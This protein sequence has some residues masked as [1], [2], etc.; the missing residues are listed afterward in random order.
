MTEPALLGVSPAPSCSSG[1][2]VGY[3]ESI[4]ECKT[5]FFV[6]FVCLV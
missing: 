2:S 4:F 5:K 3:L 1:N 6:I